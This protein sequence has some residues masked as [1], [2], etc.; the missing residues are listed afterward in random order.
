M[1][2]ITPRHRRFVEEYCGGAKFNGAEA[3]RRAGYAESRANV[4][5]SE[6]LADADINQMVE[7]RL[8][9]LAMTA[10]EATKRLAD[11]ARADISDFFSVESGRLVLDVEAVAEDGGGVISEISLSDDGTHKIKLYD[12]QKAL[13]KILDAH[14]AF[15]HRQEIDVTTPDGI[16]VEF[17]GEMPD[18]AAPPEVDE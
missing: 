12:A 6:L 9:K 17:V 15:N 2:N 7:E 3:A 10:A 13:V 4:T 5:A 14:G 1:K 11:Q 16:E 8:D 18:I